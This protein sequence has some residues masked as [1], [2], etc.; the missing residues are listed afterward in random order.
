MVYE[1]KE[2]LKYKVLLF[3]AFVAECSNL[4]IIVQELISPFNFVK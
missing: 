1:D 4:L 2:A 3:T